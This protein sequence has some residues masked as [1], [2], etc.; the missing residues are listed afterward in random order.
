MLLVGQLV[1]A[2]VSGFC[3]FAAS[4]EH[5]ASVAI[6]EMSRAFSS[7]PA[8]VTYEQVQLISALK[9]WLYVS[10]HFPS[11]SYARCLHVT[12]HSSVGLSALALDSVDQR[13][14][15]PAVYGPYFQSHVLSNIP[16]H[17]S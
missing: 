1:P 5:F 16:S 4:A 15:N 9:L 17:E 2:V 6:F 11:L 10:P 14:E 3:T 8:T 13:A 7:L 12:Y